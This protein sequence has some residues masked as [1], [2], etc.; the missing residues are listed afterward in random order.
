MNNNLLEKYVRLIVKSGINIQK[1][2]TLVIIS[3]IEC[4]SF[5]RMIAKTAFEEGARDVVLEWN[6][7]LLSKIKYLYAPEEIFEEFP[8]WQKNFYISYAKEGAA[9][10]TIDAKNP[11]L[12]DRI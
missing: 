6:D 9:F 4:A 3:S 1:N 8:E 11:E 7:E 12:R 10:L 5:V 2:Q